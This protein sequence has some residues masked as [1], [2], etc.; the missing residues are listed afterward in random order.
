MRDNLD[1]AH[2]PLDR[3]FLFCKQCCGN[4]A[5]FTAIRETSQSFKFL[6][7]AISLNNVIL[8]RRNDI[9]TFRCYYDDLPQHVIMIIPVKPK[10]G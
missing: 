2:L 10:R 5:P 1:L 4:H 6:N 9:W 7:N 3:L 8:F